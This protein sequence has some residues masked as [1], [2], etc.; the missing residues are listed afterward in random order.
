MLAYA[1]MQIPAAR[2]C[3]LE[4]S[5]VGEL[6]RRLCRWTEI[7]RAAQ[8]PGNVLGEHVKHLA[9]GISSSYSLGDGRETGQ[10]PIPPCRQFAALHVID[11][12]GEAASAFSMRLRSLGAPTRSTVQ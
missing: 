4:I 3:G 2:R 8:Q 11:F 5:R 9:G 6:Q 12:W 10:I 1:E 7:R